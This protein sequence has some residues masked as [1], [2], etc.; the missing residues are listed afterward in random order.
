MLSNVCKILHN[1]QCVAVLIQLYKKNVVVSCVG[2]DL[3]RNPRKFFF[4]FY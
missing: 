3:L 4:P 2:S 1:K